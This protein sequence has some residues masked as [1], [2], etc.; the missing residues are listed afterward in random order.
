MFGVIRTDADPRDRRRTLVWIVPKA[1][2]RSQKRVIS[3]ADAAVAR[4]LG[5][6]SPAEVDEVMAALE[7]VAARLD[8][9]ADHQADAEAS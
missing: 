5:A 4:A 6:A 8:R 3:T 2:E 9:A 1:V 7:M